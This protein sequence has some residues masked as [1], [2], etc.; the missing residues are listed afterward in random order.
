MPRTFREI[1]N[2]THVSEKVLG[3]CYKLELTFNLTPGSSAA[4]SG[5]PGIAG[6]EVL[7]VRYCNHLDLPPH[8]MQGHYRRCERAW[9]RGWTQPRVDR[10]E[11]EDYQARVPS[12]L[13]GPCQAGQGVDS[14]RESEHE[15][16]TS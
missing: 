8:D 7:L 14:R 16:L 13:R 12:V 11:R 2:L 15:P 6:P 3:Q 1:C 9:Y 4:R 10:S 5:T